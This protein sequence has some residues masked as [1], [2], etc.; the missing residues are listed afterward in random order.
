MRSSRADTAAPDPG[1]TAPTRRRFLGYLL[2]APT[3]VAAAELGGASLFG[4]SAHAAE[5]GAGLPPTPQV[6]D[7]VDLTDG[8]VYAARPTANLIAVQLNEDGSA[9]FALHRTEVGQGLTTAI[10][11][12]IAEEL[13]LPLEKVHITLADARPELVF[14]QLTGGSASISA[15]YWPVRTAAAVAKGRLL[16]AASHVLGEQTDLLTAKLG[17]ITS[18]AGNAI[19]YGDLVHRAASDTTRQV[20][21]TLK[22]ESEFT[23]VGKPTRRIDALEAVTGRKKFTTDL[24]VP[25][26]KPTMVCRPPTINGTVRGAKNLD[27][28]RRMPGITDVVEISSGVAVRGETFGQCIDAVNALDVS[29]GP[30]PVDDESD[31]TVERKLKAATP[32]PVIPPTPATKTLERQYTF[33]FVNGSALGVNSAIAD[34]RSD[35]AEIW[36][37]VKVPIVAQAAIASELGLAQ[38]QVTVHVVPGGGSFGRCLFHDAAS[39]AAEISKKIGKPVKLMWHRADDCRQGRVH[40]MSVGTIRASFTDDVISLEQHLANV[41]TDFSHGFGEALTSTATRLPLGGYSVSEVIF[42]L[43]TPSLYNFGVTKTLLTETHQSPA[44]NQKRGGFNTGSTRNVYSPDVATT[45]ELFV[46]ELAEAMGMDPYSFRRKYVKNENLLKVLDKAAEVGGW[47]QPTPE[48]VGHGI[49]LH[50]EYKNTMACFV[51]IDCRPETVNRPVRNG[52]TGPRVTR[53]VLVALPGHIV[54]NPLGLEAM[55]Q[56]GFIDGFAQALTASVHLD[57]GAIAEA[58]WDNFFYCRQWNL[59]FEFTPVILPAEESEMP[60]GGG[61]MGVAPAFAATACAYRAAT[62][63]TPTHFPI[64]HKDPLAFEPY[65]HVPPLPPSPTNGLDYSY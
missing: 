2:A 37:T 49:A 8:L 43:T 34:V 44:N 5:T 60:S 9:S 32:P 29:W 26:A 57:K 48:G 21:A 45:R 58:S 15:L 18:A 52:V 59:P 35:R 41:R 25:D 10:A 56:G 50:H 6:A 38:E 53:G 23:V 3:L 14:N 33:S 30:G 39:E 36:S 20:E 28:V 27:E 62:G 63:T 31:D 16:E 22:P 17:T 64:N 13:E 51:E 19:P 47:G 1:A 54:V 24:Q 12:L 46:D 11:M 4:P 7:H 42:T 61:E 40:P 65:P 55:M